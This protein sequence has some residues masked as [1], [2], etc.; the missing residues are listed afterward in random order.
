[1][2]VEDDEYTLSM[3][4]DHDS[5]FS[6]MIEFYP[7]DAPMWA[8]P[9]R[10]KYAFLSVD[11]CRGCVGLDTL[12]EIRAKEEA[13][14]RKRIRAEKLSPSKRTR[15]GLKNYRYYWHLDTATVEKPF[16]VYMCGNDDVSY[17]KFFETLEEAQAFADHF[18]ACQ[19]LTSADV[20]TTM[21]FTN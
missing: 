7:D 8:G 9:F 20:Q 13:S 21:S 3:S 14:L 11:D 19:P 18:V 5:V 12:E 15:I 10:G 1:M 16:R 4:K 2:K 6:A 17:S